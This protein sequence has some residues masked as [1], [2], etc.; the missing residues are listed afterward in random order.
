MKVGIVCPYDL[1]Q[2]GG[3]QQHCIEL[4]EQLR[5]RGD[6]VVVVGAGSLRRHGGPGRDNAT[7]PIGRAF[8]IRANDSAV[9]LTLSLRSWK[10]LH[11]ELADVDV[12]H[13]HEPLIPLVGWAAL[14]T[15]KPMV[16]TFHADAPRW[17][18]SLYLSIPLLAG[19]MRSAVITA[20]S[21]T[22]KGALPESWGHVRVIPNGVDVSSY[23]VPVG[24]VD[25]RI[26]FLGRD[27]P[28]KGLDIALEA[29]AT[30][31]ESHTDAELMV[32]GSDRGSVLPG[33]RFLGRVSEGEKRR[34]LA[35]SGVY[36]A[37][38]TG[39]ESFGIVIAE[40]MAAGCAV[41]TSDIDAFRDVVGDHGVLFPVG[42]TAALARSIGHLLDNPDE[43]RRLAAG[44]KT[45]VE[46][47]DWGSIIEEYRTAYVDAIAS[48]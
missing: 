22:A 5:T 37:P 15:N 36:V 32:M 14:R 18:R 47:Y 31:R 35:S 29:F 16:A 48:G 12:V 46:S 20:V 41:I 25:R 23:E 11:R 19:R 21:D 2:P 3:V 10:R 34:I 6:S 7:V 9:P 45:A 8:K 26:A 33:V 13:L 42:D 43:L 44:G 17:A 27:D 1:A 40:A 38:N 4:A 39:G 24:R 30:V 28:R